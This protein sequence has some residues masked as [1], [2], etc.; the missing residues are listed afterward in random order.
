MKYKK[1]HKNIYI[2]KFLK[3]NSKN[4]KLKYKGKRLLEV[5]CE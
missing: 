3:K 1:R 2:I 5:D 4:E